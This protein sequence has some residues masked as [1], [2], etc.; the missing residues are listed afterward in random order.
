MNRRISGTR[1]WAVA[2]INCC[3]GC[4]HNCRYCY[5]RLA[6]VK[7]GAIASADQWP[8]GRIDAEM[9]AAAHPCYGGQVMF[10]TAH[11]IIDDNLEAAMQVIANLL[12][13]GNRVL[14]VSKPSLS[15]IEQICDRLIEDRERLLFRFSITARNE[16]ILAFWEPGAPPY[17]ERLRALERAFSRGFAT[18]ISIEPLLDVGDIEGL[19]AEL[20]PFVTHSI[21]I[22]KMNRIEERVTIESAQTAAE[23]ERIRTQQSD[24]G[25]KA[26]Y[27]S[28]KDHPLIRWKES[29]KAVV[30][31]ELLSECGH[32]R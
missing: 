13:A 16:A 8:H 4:P 21:W 19:V 6:A 24:A 31:L 25:I 29:I 3:I 7:S 20:A 27:E 23:V 14:V 15:C 18:S 10:P 26:L 32:D 12:A 28:L 17:R 2:E 11:D 1:E 9:V 5:A 30:G 22:G